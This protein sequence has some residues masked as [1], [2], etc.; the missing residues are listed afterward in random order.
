VIAQIAPRN[1]PSGDGEVEGREFLLGWRG[2]NLWHDSE[3]EETRMAEKRLAMASRAGAHII[4]PACPFRLIHFEDAIK[5]GGL[6]DEMKVIDL[7]ELRM[8]TR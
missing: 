6:E 1:E 7:M 4:A 8:S 5:A 2:F 3:Q